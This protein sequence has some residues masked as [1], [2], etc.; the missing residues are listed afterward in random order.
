MILEITPHVAAIRLCAI[1][2]FSSFKSN[3]DVISKIPFIR[4]SM[5]Q[6]LRQSVKLNMRQ[7]MMNSVP[8][9]WKQSMITNVKKCMKPF[10]R[11]KNN[12]ENL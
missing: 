12:T 3:I 8:Q 1:T 4:P 7:F 5:T 6:S 2:P 11:Y 10:T 9:L